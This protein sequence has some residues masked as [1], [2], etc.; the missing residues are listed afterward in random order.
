MSYCYNSTYVSCV[1]QYNRIWQQEW[2]WHLL[3]GRYECHANR[4]KRTALK[5]LTPNLVEWNLL[6]TIAEEL[7][8]KWWPFAK[9]TKNKLR[10]A[11]QHQWQAH[12]TGQKLQYT[13]MV[14]WTVTQTCKT[15]WLEGQRCAFPSKASAHT[16]YIIYMWQ[17]QMK[18]IRSSTQEVR[19]IQAEYKT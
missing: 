3:T 5:W 9:K 16:A 6:L 19:N 4:L 11:N 8:V 17:H 1:H 7:I 15:L 12:N 14:G 2:V 13:T 10:N 18:K